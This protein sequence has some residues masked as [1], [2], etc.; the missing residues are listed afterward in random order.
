MHLTVKVLLVFESIYRVIEC[1]LVDSLKVTFFFTSCLPKWSILFP[2]AFV[3]SYGT[4]T[5]KNVTLSIGQEVGVVSALEYGF[6]RSISC[7]VLALAAFYFNLCALIFFT[8]TC[9]V[10]FY[11]I[12]VKK[13]MATSPGD[14]TTLKMV[15]FSACILGHVLA[16]THA[17]IIA[18]HASKYLAFTKGCTHPEQPFKPDNDVSLMISTSVLGIYHI[19]AL[20]MGSLMVWSLSKSA[21][22]SQLNQSMVIVDE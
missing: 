16:F 22:G 3:R 17:T 5:I 11:L 7:R 15:M 13:S 20:I 9:S 1:V 12:V 19:L 4:E 14:S 2:E 21:E 10:R 6:S 18:L 8:M